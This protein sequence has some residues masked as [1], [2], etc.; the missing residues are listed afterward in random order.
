MW[1]IP[2]EDIEDEHVFAMGK[3]AD[4]VFN[5]LATEGQG[6]Y[7]AEMGVVERS[8]Y[9]GMEPQWYL[10]KVDVNYDPDS[11][12]RANATRVKADLYNPETG[13]DLYSAMNTPEFN[14]RWFWDNPKQNAIREA[15]EAKH[16]NKY[17][18]F[19]RPE[20]I[21]TQKMLNINDTTI[22]RHA[23]DDD[24]DSRDLTQTD[25]IPESVK[26]QGVE[27]KVSVI[28]NDD[29][30]A[31]YFPEREGKAGVYKED[32]TLDQANMWKEAIEANPDAE[33]QAANNALDY[34]K[35]G[36]PWLDDYNR[37]A[38]GLISIGEGTSRALD[39][40][41]MSRSEGIDQ[42]NTLVDTH[43]NWWQ[44]PQNRDLQAL[45]HTGDYNDITENDVI[46]PEDQVKYLEIYA[47]KQLKE[48]LTEEDTAF[49][50]LSKYQ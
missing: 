39:T 42:W 21:V 24:Y 1:N 34:F 11:E 25:N 33:Y 16:G 18:D 19:A 32:L 5:Q 15:Y 12:R 31:V 38:S 49:T 27:G 7:D 6:V 45:G 10:P 44:S 37:L 48:D 14:T 29:G 50:Q 3:K 30:F 17:T 36:D 20:G 4:E 41:P 28:T 9:E 26:K 46:T 40:G 23:R 35:S 8:D 13:T 47:K 43:T 2:V 22:L